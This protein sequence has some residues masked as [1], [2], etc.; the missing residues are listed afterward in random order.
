VVRSAR[1]SHDSDPAAPLGV[2]IRWCPGFHAVLWRLLAI[3]RA[4]SQ[5]AI[6]CS[7]CDS[8]IVCC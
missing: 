7:G 4:V 2:W 3:Q 1:I 5:G 8:I 6:P